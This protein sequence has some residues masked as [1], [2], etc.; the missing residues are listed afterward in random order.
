MYAVGN[1]PDWDSVRSDFYHNEHEWEDFW[2]VYATNLT[3]NGISP[4]QIVGGVWAS[5]AWCANASAYLTRNAA[6]LG[7]FNVHWYPIWHGAA[8]GNVSD[9][10]APAAVTFPAPWQAAAAAA[11]AAGVRFTVREGNN[12]NGGGISGVSDRFAA[13][14]WALDAA[15][16]LA[17]LG[18]TAWHVNTGTTCAFNASG[19]CPFC[20]VPSDPPSPTNALAMAVRGEFYGM[21]AAA[22]AALGDGGGGAKL[23]NVSL[24]PSGNDPRVTLHALRRA[25]SAWD[26]STSSSSSS[27]SSGD[28]V[29]VVVVNKNLVSSP[30]QKDPPP[31]NAT[32]VTLCLPRS[33]TAYVETMSAPGGAGSATGIV[34]AGQTWED[35][36]HSGAPSGARVRTP[37]VPVALTG[38]SSQGSQAYALDLAAESAAVVYSSIV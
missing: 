25:S 11:A 19:Y 15:F 3:L 10:L 27:S 32:R 17:E 23:L 26:G 13:A 18:V 1:E 33:S 20:G 24:A 9:L 22:R 30:G 12:I 31:S 8:T 14:L 4:Q 6:L 5:C 38:C 16:A 21:V 28:V 29:V 37:L 2:R 34:L 7:E 36:A 35:G